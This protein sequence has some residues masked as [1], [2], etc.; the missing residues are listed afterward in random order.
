MAKEIR[1]EHYNGEGYDY[2]I[3][4]SQILLLC[5]DC[6]TVLSGEIIK[7]LKMGV[8]AGKEVDI[9]RKLCSKHGKAVVWSKNPDEICEMVEDLLNEALGGGE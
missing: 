7:K 4:N 3:S 9:Y 8:F 6:N 1:C 2:E 5:K